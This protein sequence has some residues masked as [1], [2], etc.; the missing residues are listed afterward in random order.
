MYTDKKFS[1]SKY[2]QKRFVILFSIIL[3]L[4]KN[5]HFF[6]TEIRKFSTH[7]VPSV[8]KITLPISLLSQKLS[9]RLII[10]GFDLPNPTLPTSKIIEMPNKMNI[11]IYDPLGLDITK[12]DQSTDKVIDM[13]TVS[14]MVEK[15]SKQRN[16]K[17]TNILAIRRRKMKKHKKRKW[18]K[19]YKFFLR[20]KEQNKAIAR[21]KRFQ[22]EMQDMLKEAKTF[23]AEEYVKSRLHLLVRKHPGNMWEGHYVPE[24]LYNELK[25][26]HDEKRAEYIKSKNYKLKLEDD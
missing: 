22:A 13:P 26:K 9:P 2:I 1:M 3:F 14:T 8:S 17:I 24:E 7:Q 5:F 11:E 20:R 10:N 21:E 23:D 6:I 15:Y 18:R 16:R 25:R 19:K 4:C 12:G